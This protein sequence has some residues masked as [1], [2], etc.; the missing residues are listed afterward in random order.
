[1]QSILEKF[2]SR[3][4]GAFIGAIF[5]GYFAIKTLAPEQA[6]MFLDFLQWVSGGYLLAQGGVDITK[7]LQKRIAQQADVEVEIADTVVIEQP[8]KIGKPTTE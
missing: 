6:R 7:E 1:M 8:E 5:A 2:L 4:L 3:K